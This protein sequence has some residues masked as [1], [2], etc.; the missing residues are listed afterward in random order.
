MFESADDGTLFIDEVDEIPMAVQGRLLRALE[1]GTFRRVGGREPLKSDVRIISATS[2][3]LLQM[4]AA[5]EF[6]SDLYYRLAGIKITMP[7][8]RERAS[9]IPA[10][11]ETL[12]KRMD[13][14]A[15]KAYS[16]NAAATKNWRV[17]A[18]RATC[19]R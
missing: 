6:R 15:G 8:L 13:S 17:T 12:L 2:R 7:P 4:V 9:D 19:R 1:S 14:K 18:F 10:L 16:L 5:G 11:A 3:N